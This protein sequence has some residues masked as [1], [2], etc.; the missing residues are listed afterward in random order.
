MRRPAATSR[1]ACEGDC[2]RERS[3]P[4]IAGTLCAAAVQLTAGHLG[5]LRHAGGTSAGPPDDSGATRGDHSADP[6][7]RRRV[8][9]WPVLL[10]Q[11]IPPAC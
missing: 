8:F 9:G 6:S 1:A 2:L 4:A 11:R 3:H 7:Q 5:D 10:W